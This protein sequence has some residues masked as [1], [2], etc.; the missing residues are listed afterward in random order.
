MPEDVEIQPYHDPDYQDWIWQQEDLYP[1]R[2]PARHYLGW[3]L[4]S[5]KWDGRGFFYELF[6]RPDS[7]SVS[8]IMRVCGGKVRAGNRHP[9]IRTALYR[10]SDSAD[11]L[12]YIGITND[13]D[14]RF[15]QHAKDKPW[16]PK[17]SQSTVE[18]FDNGRL[19]L[20]AEAAAIR[21]EKPLHNVVHNSARE[22]VA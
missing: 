7:D 21:S 18:W 4:N 20:A 6:P 15:E 10:L 13:P 22:A 2:M 5:C 19:A 11:R 12:L 17:V 9:R 16:W 1:Q 3:A 8:R 14:R